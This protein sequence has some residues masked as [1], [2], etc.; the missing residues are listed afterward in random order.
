MTSFLIS[1]FPDDYK[2]NPTILTSV[3]L[4]SIK[5][6]GVFNTFGGARTLLRENI[7]YINAKEDNDPLMRY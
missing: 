7:L 5:V 2:K 3:S 4:I 6:S 1:H